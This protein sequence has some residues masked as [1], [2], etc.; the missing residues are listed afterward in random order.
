MNGP[1]MNGKRRM[2]VSFRANQVRYLA[3]SKEKKVKDA[4]SNCRKNVLVIHTE[5]D[6]VRDF[7]CAFCIFVAF[8]FG[9]G[10]SI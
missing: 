6:R 10:A 1:S 2:N 8:F 9:L 3:V 4:L 5:A 7:G